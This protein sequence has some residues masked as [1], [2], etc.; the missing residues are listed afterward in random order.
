MTPSYYVFP[1]LKMA[2]LTPEQLEGIKKKNIAFF[3]SNELVSEIRKIVCQF[4]GVTQEQLEGKR[5][6]GIL[7]WARQVFCYMCKKYTRF[8]Q[9]GIGDLIN[10]DHTTIIHSVRIVNDNIYTYPEFKEQIDSIESNISD[11]IYTKVL[12]I[13]NSEEGINNTGC[14]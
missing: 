11:K 2:Y 12:T 10:R 1:G 4:Y 9:K 14:S 6:K 5:G 13:K 7:P 8:T 3:R